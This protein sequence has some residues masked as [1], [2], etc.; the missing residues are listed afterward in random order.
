[1]TE[2]SVAP[3]IG[4]F[5]QKRHPQVSPWCLIDPLRYEPEPD[6]P[7]DGVVFLPLIARN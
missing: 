1:M 4:G 2:Q 7:V 3:F 6:E 5:L